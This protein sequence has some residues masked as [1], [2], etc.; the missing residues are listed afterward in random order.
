M[1]FLKAI[2]LDNVF[3]KIVPL[4][5]PEIIDR[6]HLVIR[7]EVGALP[8]SEPRGAKAGRL[9][10]NLTDRAVK[11]LDNSAHIVANAVISRGG[12]VFALY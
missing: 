5:S 12:I 3:T 9:A 2:C 8:A 6:F 4:T 11:I 1:F 7:S 10:R